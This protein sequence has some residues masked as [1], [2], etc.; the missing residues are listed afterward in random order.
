MPSCHEIC[1]RYH[2]RH[3]VTKMKRHTGMSLKSV[4]EKACKQAVITKEMMAIL[5]VCIKE[6]QGKGAPGETSTE[7]GTVVESGRGQAGGECSRLREIRGEHNMTMDN[8]EWME[9]G[10]MCPRSLS[11]R[12]KKE[13]EVHRLCMLSIFFSEYR[14][15]FL[16]T[17]P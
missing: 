2:T 15:T 6:G 12:G 14:Q 1:A 3:W 10:E 16:V 5:E 8:Q 4:G 17:A 13:K 11:G 9:R 7:G